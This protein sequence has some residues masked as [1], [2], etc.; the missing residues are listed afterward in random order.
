M[1]IDPDAE[2]AEPPA[3][4]AEGEEPAEPAPKKTERRLSE[5]GIVPVFAVMLQAPEGTCRARFSHAKKGTTD[6]FKAHMDHFTSRNL[7]DGQ[8]S[9]ADFFQDV[10]KIGVFNLPIAMKSEEDM[11]ESTRIYME[12]GGRP[13]NYLKSADEVAD[14]LLT[15]Q[16]QKEDAAA[17]MS[18]TMERQVSVAK[19]KNDADNKRH[20]ERQRIIGAHESERSQLEELSLREYLMRYMV[21]NLTE[22]LIEMCMVMPENPVDYLATYL[23]EHAATERNEN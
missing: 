5:D 1:P 14:Q 21:P 19:D 16:R 2:D 6:D 22:G 8:S 17:Q 18:A 12:S 11:F 20:L 23:E 10:A 13:F 3:E 4:P 7:L 15:K 9:F